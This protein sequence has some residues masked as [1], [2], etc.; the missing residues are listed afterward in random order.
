M[1]VRNDEECLAFESLSSNYVVGPLERYHC[2]K[3]LP[4]KLVNVLENEAL[5][6]PQGFVRSF[7]QK[8]R[9]GKN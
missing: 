5:E 6:G 3:P 2:K 4:S 1:C 8:G 7:Q 9:E